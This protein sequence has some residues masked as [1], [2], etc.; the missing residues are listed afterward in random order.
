MVEQTVDY[1]GGKSS[2]FQN[3]EH[4]FNYCSALR[5]QLEPTGLSC[6]NGMVKL[7]LTMPPEPLNTLQSGQESLSQHFL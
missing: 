1:A 4:N 3:N 2:L 6:A 5:F 7:Q